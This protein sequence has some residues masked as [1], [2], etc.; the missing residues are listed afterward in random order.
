MK[1]YERC[2]ND[3]QNVAKD[4]CRSKLQKYKSTGEQT[5][6]HPK[7][8]FN[9]HTKSPFDPDF[10]GCPPWLWTE[11]DLGQENFFWPARMILRGNDMFD[12]GDMKTK[13]LEE[14]NSI[15]GYLT[16]YKIGDTFYKQ[17]IGGKVK[18]ETYGS[19]K[20]PEH[21]TSE[22]EIF[23]RKGY[24][25]CH[26]KIAKTGEP[27]PDAHIF[28]RGCF[29]NAKVRPVMIMKKSSTNGGNHARI[30]PWQLSRNRSQR[31]RFANIKRLSLHPLR[32]ARSV[33]GKVRLNARPE[34]IFELI[35]LS[36]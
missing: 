23:A 4:L 35:L 19:G 10:T 9:G 33:N 20:A 7:Y 21:H 26:Q 32:R 22:T 18:E 12:S 3:W 25:L 34:V 24:G 27:I 2:I 15:L 36:L 8:F 31:R 14:C 28:N 6:K 13:S 29:Q 17:K 5:R 11:A 30:T 16:V 1:N